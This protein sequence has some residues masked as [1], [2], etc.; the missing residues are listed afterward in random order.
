MD[1]FH[2]ERHTDGSNFRVTTNISCFTDVV[3]R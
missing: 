3:V 2:A 1:I